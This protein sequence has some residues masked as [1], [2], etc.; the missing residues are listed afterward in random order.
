MLSII[1]PTRNRSNLLQL[2]LLSLQAQTL[3]Q[4]EFEVLVIDNGSTDNTKQVV[5]SFQG[6]HN[7]RYFFDPTPGLHVGRHRGLKEAKSDILVY[8]DDDIQALPTW[9]EA[10]AENFADDS[11]AMVGGNNYPDF[12]APPP[13]WIEELWNQPMS[14]G[15][16]IPALSVIELPDGRREFTPHQVWGCNFSIRKQVLL[17]A[18]GFHPDG[19]PQENIR[20][21][22]DGETYVSKFVIDRGLRCIFDSRASVLHAVT[23]ER[24]TPEY[25][26][27][28]AFNQGV[29]DSYR[30]VRQRSASNQNLLRILGS[31]KK[32]KYVGQILRDTI[33]NIIRPRTK[34]LNELTREM[35]LAYWEGFDYHQK[36]YHQD[37]EVHAWVHQDHYL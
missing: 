4:S 12:K 3:G 37:R 36:Q 29:S 26:R 30:W 18:G 34:E 14:G 23:P 2:A 22:G 8:A 28:R 31:A 16:A 15:H 13:A 24:M 35:R 25:F 17:D 27:K 32:I 9:L 33:H 19:V 20:F 1:I 10:I 6:L 7:L 5:Q 11:V 21:R